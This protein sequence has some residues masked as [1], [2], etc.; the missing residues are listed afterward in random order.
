MSTPRRLPPAKRAPKEEPSTRRLPPALPK[1]STPNTPSPQEL[2]SGC[3]PTDI[4]SGCVPKK[5]DSRIHCIAC[6]GSGISSIKTRCVPCK[7]T[8]RKKHGTYSPV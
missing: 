7:G 1:R 6:S 5:F 2:G 3:V 8:G 4:A